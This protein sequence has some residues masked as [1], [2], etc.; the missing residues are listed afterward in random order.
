MAGDLNEMF[1]SLIQ[2]INESGGGGG[3]A[4]SLGEVIRL[5]DGQT[6]PAGLWINFEIATINFPPA[7]NPY[8]GGQWYDMSNMQIVPSD[9]TLVCNRVG[10]GINRPFMRVNV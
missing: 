9:G 10:A 8:G 6:I 3:G 1:N 4:V 5:N 7:L 2:Q